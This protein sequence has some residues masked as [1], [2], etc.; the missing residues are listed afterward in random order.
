MVYLK[1]AIVFCLIILTAN[2]L[3][4]QSDP[5][6]PDEILLG[7]PCEKTISESFTS[8]EPIS[9]NG[10][11]DFSIK[12]SNFGWKGN[13]SETSPM[14]TSHCR[15]PSHLFSLSLILMCISLCLKAYLLVA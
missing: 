3:S 13:G 15:K 11:D 7:N 10:N 8:Y 12:A 2:S 4:Y 5:L 14:S 6:L 1:S 9:I